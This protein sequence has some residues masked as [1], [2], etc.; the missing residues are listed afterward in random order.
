MVKRRWVFSER[1]LELFVVSELNQVVGEVIT[2]VERV[3]LYL[4]YVRQKGGTSAI[5][6]VIYLTEILQLARCL[7]L[8]LYCCRQS[9][10]SLH[11]LLMVVVTLAEILL[12]LSFSW[13]SL[14]LFNSFVRLHR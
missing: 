2:Q 4:W 12:G 6:L 14:G 1:V 9:E 5:S 13:L 10:I 7:W 3:L 8:M 11:L